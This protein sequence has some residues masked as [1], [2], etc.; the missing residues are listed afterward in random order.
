MEKKTNYIILY[1]YYYAHFK[2]NTTSNPTLILSQFFH[3]ILYTNNKTV[4][5]TWKRRHQHPT[6]YIQHRI[7]DHYQAKYKLLIFITPIHQIHHMIQNAGKRHLICLLVAL[8][9]LEF[10]DGLHRRMVRPHRS[11]LF[12]F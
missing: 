6:R 3:N 10:P 11:P 9:E 2:S 4:N 8:F 1:Y 7:I 12:G 5:S